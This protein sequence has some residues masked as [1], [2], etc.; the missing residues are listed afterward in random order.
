MSSESHNTND[1]SVSVILKEFTG[2]V[3]CYL[4]LIDLLLDKNE[5]WVSSLPFP[6]CSLSN[7]GSR[8]VL[9]SLEMSLQS[10]PLF[11]FTVLIQI[12]VTLCSCFPVG[13]PVS[14]HLSPRTSHILSADEWL[15]TFLL[16]HRSLLKDLRWLPH[17]PQQLPVPSN[18]P[19]GSHTCP[20]H[21]RPSSLS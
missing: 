3:R 5:T 13:L 2:L 12:H 4:G 8:A 20:R 18:R 1:F 6:S 14:F 17:P 10:C 15:K 7:P 19:L 11:P 16:P 9:S 21:P